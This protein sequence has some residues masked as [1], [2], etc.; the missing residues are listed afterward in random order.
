MHHGRDAAHRRGQRVRPAD[1]TPVDRDA[2]LAEPPGVLLGQREHPH[3]V[4]AVLQ[5]RDQMPA[6]QAVAA[7]DQDVHVAV[8]SSRTG[9]QPRCR[10]MRSAIPGSACSS[11]AIA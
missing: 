8:S 4:A 3:A 1:V 11:Q 10:C 7:G 6:E 5:D 9:D 2:A